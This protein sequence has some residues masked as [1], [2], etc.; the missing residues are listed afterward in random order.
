MLTTRLAEQLEIPESQVLA[1]LR[2]APLLYK[3]YKIPKR[4]FGVRTIAQPTPHL[5]DLQ[6]AFI[7]ICPLS[8]H[9]AATAYRPGQSI[10]ENARQHVRNSYLL[11]LDLNNF[12][13]SITPDIFW[14]EWQHTLAMPSPAEKKHIEQLLFWAPGRSLTSSLVLSV[15]APSS[16][17]VSNFIMYRLDTRLT[18]LCRAQHITYTRYADDLIFSC[19]T[20]NI[21]FSLPKQVGLLLDELFAGQISINKR[22]TAFS[23]KAHNRHVTGIC[24]TSEGKLSL[25]RA[26]KRYLKHL[27][28]Q[29]NLG[30]LELAQIRQLQGWLAHAKHIEPTF[31]TTLTKKHGPQILKQIQEVK[32]D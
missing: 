2:R 5:K 25:G 8:A 9:P 16:P 28:H 31:I 15:G 17:A 20:R 32:H 12:F 1:T 14:Q 13:N 10:R 19:N 22:K 7:S 3:V 23:S 30:Y 6:R 26:K 4:S 18:E 21:L 11:K 24:L 29:Y 27:V